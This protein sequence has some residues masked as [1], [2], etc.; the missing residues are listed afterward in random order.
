MQTVLTMY[1]LFWVISDI[2]NLTA[3]LKVETDNSPL[4]FQVIIVGAT[5][6]KTAGLFPFSSD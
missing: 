3:I 2:L 4:R 5:V 6:M 1:I